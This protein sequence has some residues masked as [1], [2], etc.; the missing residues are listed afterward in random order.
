M[1]YLFNMAKKKKQNEKKKQSIL[2]TLRFLKKWKYFILVIILYVI[3]ILLYTIFSP[4]PLP[5][6]R[7][8]RID[9]YFS[10]HDAPLAGHGQTFV[11]AADT[12]GM[13]WRLLPSIAMQESTGGKR[14]QLNN[15]FGW[16]SAEIPFQSIDEAILGV[17]HNLCGF[18]TNTAKWY[19]T[20][21]TQKKLYYYNGTVA[22]SYPAEV[23]WIMEQI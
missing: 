18:N 1:L 11:D 2:P 14:M 17:G 16:G 8:G 5:D 3:S 22:P 6:D 23:M 21:S 20:T 19:S 13:D 12:C 9:A 4:A 15:P 10:K 7:P